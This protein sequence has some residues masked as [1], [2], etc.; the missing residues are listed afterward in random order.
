MLDKIKSIFTSLSRNTG[1]LSEFL[2]DKEFKEFLKGW[3]RL[4]RWALFLYIIFITSSM[5][6]YVDNVININE[7]MR[8][9][10]KLELNYADIQNRNKILKSKVIE[11]QEA[12]RICKIAEVNLKMIK[13]DKAPIHIKQ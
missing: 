13:N 4:N 9:I 8:D 5:V 11:L 1:E 10:K 3:L 2:S 12:D 7:L 6:F